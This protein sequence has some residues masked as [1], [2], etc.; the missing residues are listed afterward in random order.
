MRIPLKNNHRDSDHADLLG[1]DRQ[2]LSL[3]R[4]IVASEAG[5]SDGDPEAHT[6]ACP[7]CQT[8]WLEARAQLALIDVAEGD[9]PDDDYRQQSLRQ[10]LGDHLYTLLSDA[11][12][13]NLEGVRAV[14]NRLAR[15]RQN[16]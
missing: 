12:P 11:H 9:S 5:G 7:H 2:R 15:P 16:A 3:Y 8:F 1:C 10:R 14:L 6:R 13:L 4:D